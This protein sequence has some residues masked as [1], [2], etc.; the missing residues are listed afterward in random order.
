MQNGP[1]TELKQI[2]SL[3]LIDA[4]PECRCHSRAKIMDTLGSRWCRDNIETIVDWLEEEAANRK[5]LFDREA[6]RRMALIAI[7]RGSVR[8]VR[9]H[10]FKSNNDSRP[11]AR[12]FVVLWKYTRRAAMFFIGPAIRF[13]LARP[14]LR[15]V[16]ARHRRD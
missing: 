9:V 10:L 6:A 11:T 4:T 14:R 13:L 1:G 15:R 16:I 8:N 3:M 5:V 12:I 2:F 7:R